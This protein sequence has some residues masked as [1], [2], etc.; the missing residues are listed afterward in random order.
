MDESTKQ[1]LVEREWLE[2]LLNDSSTWIV[3]DVDARAPNLE[4]LGSGLSGGATITR[5]SQSSR[6]AA[7]YTVGDWHTRAGAEAAFVVQFGHWLSE[8]LG[9]ESLALARH[10]QC[11][12]GCA[13]QTSREIDGWGRC[14]ACPVWVDG[15]RHEFLK[16]E[17]EA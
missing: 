1:L 8:Y 14:S 6:G 9:V 17:Q 5:V 10:E 3:G 13:R 12:R 15:R 16:H 2:R 4:G 7:T 11:A